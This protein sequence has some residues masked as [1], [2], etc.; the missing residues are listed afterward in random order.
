MRTILVLADLADRLAVSSVAA[1]RRRRASCRVLT[2]LQLGLGCRW[3]HTIDRSGVVRVQ[4]ESIDA[5]EDLGR[6]AAILNRLHGTRFF[7]DAVWRSDADRRYAEAELGALIVSWLA[8]ARGLV[9]G[10][11]LTGLLHH[12]ASV[13]EWLALSTRAGLPA[14]EAL[15]TT[16]ASAVDRRDLLPMDPLEPARRLTPAEAY[17]LGRNPVLLVEPVSRRLAV[18]VVAGTV[19][20]CPDVSLEPGLRRLA[21]ASRHTLLECQVGWSPRRERWV[22]CDADPHPAHVTPG[23]VETVADVLSRAATVAA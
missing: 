6:S 21:E 1:L 11:A 15:L 4:V 8:S 20:A 14:R 2:P 16:D 9:L 23:L 3:V 13:M 5:P 12:H 18:H 22:F 10:P 19:V 7:P 17:V